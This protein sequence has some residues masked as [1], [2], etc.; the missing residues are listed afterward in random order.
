[1]PLKWIGVWRSGRMSNTSC[2]HVDGQ[3]TSGERVY[4]NWA[5][6]RLAVT[7]RSV[8]VN[9]VVLQPLLVIATT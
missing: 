6:C 7:A 2:G 8:T 5:T 9:F 3:T 1:M 4:G